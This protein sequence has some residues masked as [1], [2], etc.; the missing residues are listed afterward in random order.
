M[1]EQNNNAAAMANLERF[2]EAE[3]AYLTAAKPD[4]SAIV[5][6][7]DPECVIYQPASLPYGG[8]WRGHLGFES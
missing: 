6:T 5:A 3:S 1:T 8:E 2:Y 4:F 7:L